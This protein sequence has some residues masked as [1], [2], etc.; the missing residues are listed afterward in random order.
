M[1]LCRTLPFFHFI[2]CGLFSSTLV[3]LEP[4]S[5]L[6]WRLQRLMSY[7]WRKQFEFIW[8]LKFV[9]DNSY[10]KLFIKFDR[11][12]C[13]EQ[14][15]AYPNFCGAHWIQREVT[16]KAARTRTWTVE[17][18]NCFFLQLFPSS[19]RSSRYIYRPLARVTER[20][21]YDCSQCKLLQTN[22]KNDFEAIAL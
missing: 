4:T 14:S 15:L 7:R 5:T 19:P 21:N 12:L 9:F 3:T 20:Q 11:K 2:I 17:K 10:L 22:W 13:G 16:G 6:N 18:T 8:L 1:K